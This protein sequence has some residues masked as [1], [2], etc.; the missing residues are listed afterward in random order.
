MP[1]P[2]GESRPHP[3]PPSQAAAASLLGEGRVWR[4]SLDRDAS[5][6]ARLHAFLSDDERERAA[7]FHFERDRNRFAAGRGQ[8]REVLGELLE[9][10]PSAVRFTYGPQGK[11]AL[12]HETDLRFNLSHSQDLALLAVTQNQEVGVDLEFIRP[13]LDPLEVAPSV[14]SP[15][16]CAV[17]ESLPE[18]ERIPAFYG[19]WTRKEAFIK[20]L[21]IGFTRDTR[22]FT[23]TLELEQTLEGHTILPLD[24]PPGFSAALA[25]K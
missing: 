13:D 14:F 17:L 16:E 22:E 9:I 25:I 24:A 1:S 23:V 15:D 12:A 5:E 11:P 19:Y 20:A 21:G 7:R 8:L 6:F 18:E 10:P 3:R 2:S 4:L